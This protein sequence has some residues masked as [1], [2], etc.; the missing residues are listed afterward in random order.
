MAFSL[1][2]FSDFEKIGAGGT[3]NVFSATQISASRKVIIKKIGAE[4]DHHPA[5]IKLFEKEANT[6]QH[7]QHD[8]IIRIYSHGYEDGA[9]YLV[10]EHVNGPNLEHLLQISRF[11]MDLG[12]MVV[13]QALRG[14]QYAHHNGVAHHDIKPGNILV[15]RNG[16]VKLSDF[17]MAHTKSHLFQNERIRTVFATPIYMPPEQAAI[18]QKQDLE[19]EVW[20]ETNHLAAADL[21]LGQAQALREKEFLWDIWSIGVLLYRI[22]ADRMPFT[23]D[24]LSGL[25]HAIIHSKERNIAE[26]APKLP[27]YIADIIHQCLHKEPEKRPSSLEPIISALEKYLS[28]IHAIDTEILISQFIGT[29]KEFG[30]YGRMPRI[31]IAGYPLPDFRKLVRSKGVLAAASVALVC[32]MAFAGIFMSGYKKDR[33]PKSTTDAVASTASTPAIPQPVATEI[34]A[35]VESTETPAPDTVAAAVSPESTTATIEAVQDIAQV[36]P[37]DTAGKIGKSVEVRKQGEKTGKKV[38]I[39][40][41]VPG[42]LKATIEPPNTSVYI[43]GKPVPNR[44]LLAGR[45]LPIGKHQVMAQANGYETYQQTVTIESRLTRSIAIS[46]F[47][48]EKGTGFLHVYSYPWA[49][50]Y[51]DF[52]MV[53]TSPTPNPIPLIEGEHTLQLKHDGFKKYEESVLVLK[54][55]TTRIQVNL[56]KELP[57]AQPSAAISDTSFSPFQEPPEDSLKEPGE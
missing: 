8:N 55:Q 45:Q 9:Y 31:R 36:A 53:G 1:K 26:I 28:E 21:S 14:L 16:S 15:G 34:A 50:V 46:L 17:G 23:G 20:A 49:Q 51:V 54:G 41:P 13:L 37:L 25:T 48:L 40:K 27:P 56:E 52:T 39:E 19:S 6:I 3:G 29:L 11:T 7:I 22:C 44:S 42:F 10:M 30:T 47:P 4:L 5:Q 38:R 33:S 12:L 57:V 35:P 2:D 43:D 24:T 32:I 18:I